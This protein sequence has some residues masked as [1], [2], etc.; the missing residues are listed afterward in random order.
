[1]KYK[2]VIFTILAFMLIAVIIYFVKT[3]G[4]WNKIKTDSSLQ[5]QTNFDS[6][7]EVLTITLPEHPQERTISEDKATNA[8]TKQTSAVKQ[9]KQIKARVIAYYF[10]PTARCTSCINIE[11]FSKEAVESVFKKENKAGKITFEPVNIEDSVNEHY[12]YDYNL[13]SSS[14]VLVLF[15]NNIQSEWLNLDKVWT[16]SNDKVQFINYVKPYIKQFLSKTET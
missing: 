3:I 12:I 4:P 10:H 15:K 16:Y 9:Q 8:K 14:L 13:T 7:K 2:N 1:M 5:E 11:N 6:I